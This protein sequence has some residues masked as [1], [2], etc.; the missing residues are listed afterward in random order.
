MRS[1]RFAEKRSLP[2]SPISPSMSFSVP[3]ASSVFFMNC[4]APVA[5]D[6]NRFDQP[7]C[8]ASISSSVMEVI[9]FLSLFWLWP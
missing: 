7:A 6:P 9:G 8:D 2:V 5:E 3:G 4:A 1:W